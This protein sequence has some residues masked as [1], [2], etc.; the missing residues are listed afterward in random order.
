M[1]ECQAMDLFRE[2][3]GLQAEREGCVLWD[4]RF[5]LGSSAPVA[6]RANSDRTGDKEKGFWAQTRLT[7][8]RGPSIVN[9]WKGETDEKRRGRVP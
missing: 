8:P 3:I 5:V 6:V 9:R 2:V 4:Y 1:G 7:D